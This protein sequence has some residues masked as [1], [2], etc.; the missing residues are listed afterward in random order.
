[1]SLAHFGVCVLAQNLF[2]IRPDLTFFSFAA[3]TLPLYYQCIPR[4]RLSLCV[5]PYLF[6]L[7]FAV[8]V[9]I[10]TSCC[11]FMALIPTPS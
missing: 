7:V 6:P 8:S 2:I 9:V 1:M 4:V 3:E 10:P 11:F 5:L